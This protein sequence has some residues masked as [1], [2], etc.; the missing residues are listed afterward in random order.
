M[1]ARQREGFFF[2][3]R[4]SCL[5]SSALALRNSYK[6]NLARCA[7][8]HA[9][10]PGNNKV[11]CVHGRCE[12]GYRSVPGQRAGART[13]SP[14]S[15]TFLLSPRRLHLPRFAGNPLVFAAPAACLAPACLGLAP[16]RLLFPLLRGPGC[17]IASARVR[18]SG[19]HP[20]A[21]RST[22]AL[23]MCSPKNGVQMGLK[24]TCGLS[25]CAPSFW[26]FRPDP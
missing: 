19:L 11:A 24:R 21:R 14:A 25:S 10:V 5:V 2:F 4:K 15:P 20:S 6:Y 22:T 12:C 17:T 26:G 9:S 16:A 18:R 1:P 3:L 13:S 7:W 8:L 23:G